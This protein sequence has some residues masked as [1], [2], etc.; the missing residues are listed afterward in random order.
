M[1]VQEVA[2]KWSKEWLCRCVAFQCVGAL[3]K[4]GHVV[5]RQYRP[6]EE[7]PPKVSAKV[8]VLK[9]YGGCK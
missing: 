9:C 2:L 3:C 1:Q 6:F 5:H 8:A 4:E 7:T